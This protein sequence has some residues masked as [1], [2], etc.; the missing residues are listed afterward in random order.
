MK[1]WR[2]VAFDDG[3]AGFNSEKACIVGC[4]TAGTYVE[5][6]LFDIIEID[7][8]DVTQKIASLVLKSKFR[9]QLRC[10][11][12]SGITFA[13]FN[14]ADIH[15]IHRK[16]EIPVVVVMRKQPNLNEMLNALKNVSDR[17]KRAEILKKAGKVHK[18]SEGLYVQTAGCS[19]DEARLFVKAS[20]VK[21]NIPEALRIAHLVASAIIYG[22]SKKRA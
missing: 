18:I 21:G 1:Q 4:I 16:T 9:N 8:L 20:V 15:E 6:F 14:I 12:L 19:V 2:F 10:I 3:F 11:F 13:G 22:E 5:S 7:G 17:E